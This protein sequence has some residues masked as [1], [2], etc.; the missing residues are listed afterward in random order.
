MTARRCYCG[1]VRVPGRPCGHGAPAGASPRELKRAASK[2]RQ[3]EVLHASR[4]APGYIK[5]REIQAA[6]SPPVGVFPKFNG[7]R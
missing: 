2:L 5:R 3:R 7:G 4:K 6:W 1:L